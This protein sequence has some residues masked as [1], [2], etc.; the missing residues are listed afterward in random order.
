MYCFCGAASHIGLG[1]LVVEV[2]RSYSDTPHPMELLRTGDQP[3]AQ[4]A[5]YT[6]HKKHKI[7]TAMP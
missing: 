6:T 4:A 5:T 2:S 1:L 3:V 7:R